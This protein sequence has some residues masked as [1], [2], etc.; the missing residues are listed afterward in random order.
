[1]I[2]RFTLAGNI[3]LEAALLGNLRCVHESNCFI[4]D[5]TKQTT[6]GGKSQH[7]QL[8][9][10]KF[11]E[12]GDL[13]R[14]R[15]TI[16]EAGGSNTQFPGKFQ[17]QRYFFVDLAAGYVHGIRHELTA[18]C[19]EHRRCNVRAGTVLCLDRRSAKVW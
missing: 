14:N 12:A 3:D 2:W 6:N 1:M 11:A 15:G 7:I 8:F 13:Q 9:S 10:G 19:F 16:Q 4:G 17:P 5:A 18:Q